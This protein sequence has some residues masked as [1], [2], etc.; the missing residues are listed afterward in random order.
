MKIN[1]NAPCWCGSGKKY[2][3]CH[4]HREKDVPVNPWEVIKATKQ[5]FNKEYCYAADCY[6]EE[7]TG[8]IVKAHSVSKSSNLKKIARDGHVYGFAPS[9]EN[10]AKYEGVLHP[11]LLGINKASTFT[12]FCEFHDMKIFSPIEN[13]N[14]TGKKEQ[15][16][17]LDYRAQARESFMKI[18]QADTL[19]FLKDIDKGKSLD[20]QIEIQIMNH[21]YGKAVKA[22]VRDANIYKEKHEKILISK[23]YSELKAY[24]VYFK[25]MPSVLCSAGIFPECDFHGNSLQNIYDLEITNDLISFSSIITNEGGAVVFS[26]LEDNDSKG[27]CQKFVES[28]LKIE[29]DSVSTSLIRFFFEFCE[30]VFMGPNWWEDLSHKEKDYL[31]NR[32]ASDPNLEFPRSMKCLEDDGYFFDDWEVKDIKIIN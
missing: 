12:G 26:W 1:R 3:K 22:G 8:R 14:F 29:P 30:N 18:C 11:E 28:L 9:Y 4:L 10:L 32:F 19:N 2:K 21:F 25:K 16:F 24:I 31:I 5:A 15:I 6:K 7:C 27:Y 17:L 13:E 20:E 23:D